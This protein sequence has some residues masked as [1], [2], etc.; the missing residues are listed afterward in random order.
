M[1]L[2]L[3]FHITNGCN[4]LNT[5]NV[6]GVIFAD[7]IENRKQIEATLEE[8]IPCMVINNSVEDLKIN[9]IA[10]DNV[11]GAEMAVDYLIGLGHKKIAIV[12]G[13]LQTQSGMHRL[14]GYKNILNEKNIVIKEEYIYEGDYSR[15]CARLAF[16]QFLAFK[17][18]DRPTAIFCGSDDMALEVINVAIE[19]GLKIPEDLSVVGF[20]DNPIGLYSSVGLTTIRQPLFK[21]AEDAV[22]H[23]N[24]IVLGRRHSPVKLLLTPELV[25]RESCTSPRT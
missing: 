10:V 25:V 21:M 16:D 15:R 8:G 19:K 1:R 2:D 9:Y 12:T 13:S 7:I 23:L 20:D 4:P 24:A 22:R 14:D 6:G 5:N 11:K 17:E 18:K 3:I